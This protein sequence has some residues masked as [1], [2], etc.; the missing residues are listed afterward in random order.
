MICDMPEIMSLNFVGLNNTVY[1]RSDFLQVS[2]Q[3]K[4]NVHVSVSCNRLEI[5]CICLPIS[6][7]QCDILES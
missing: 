4:Q 7:E 1:F 2:R 3:V 5:C 6:S